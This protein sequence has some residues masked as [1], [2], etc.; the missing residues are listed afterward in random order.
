MTYSKTCVTKPPFKLT[1]MVDEERWLSYKGTCHVNLLANG[2]LNHIKITIAR[3]LH[4]F[5]DSSDK[6]SGV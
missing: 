2:I 5:I 6:Q 4:M 3:L 1:L